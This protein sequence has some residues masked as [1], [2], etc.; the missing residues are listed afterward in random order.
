MTILII[1]VG[2]S[3]TGKSTL[4]KSFVPEHNIC[5][6]DTYPGLYNNGMICHELLHNAHDSCKR[7]VEHFMKQKEHTIVQSN[8]NLDL[9]EKGLKSYIQLAQFYN[10]EVHIILPCYDLLHFESNYTTRESQVDFISSQRSSGNKIVPI[11]SII[12]MVKQYDI[13]KPR[14]LQLA[15]TTDPYQMIKML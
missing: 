2:P 13:I 10:Y 14:L 15:Q 6:A 9:G 8:T 7:K 4:A 11:T 3:G 5:E 1:I 12:R